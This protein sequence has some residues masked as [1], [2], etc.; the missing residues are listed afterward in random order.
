MFLFIKYSW[1]NDMCPSLCISCTVAA[2]TMH[3]SKA[4]TANN[5]GWKKR[6]S[7]WLLKN[8]NPQKFVPHP[9]PP[10][11]TAPTHRNWT[12][13]VFFNVFNNKKSFFAFFIKLIW[14]GVGFLSRTGAETGHKL[15]KKCKKSLFIIKNIQKYRKCPALHTHTHTHCVFIALPHH[16][17]PINKIWSSEELLGLFQLHFCSAF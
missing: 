5:R 16:N 9:H 17:R 12:L 4:T 2:W 11:H 7:F 13:S 3:S 14:L 1:R 6:G 10:T 8:K 15:Y